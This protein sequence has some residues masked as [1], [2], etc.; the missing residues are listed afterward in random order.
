MFVI[1]FKPYGDSTFFARTE[2]QAGKP[3]CPHP[4]E[5]FSHDALLGTHE[6]MLSTS[7]AA[8]TFAIADEWLAAQSVRRCEMNPASGRKPPHWYYVVAAIAIVRNVMGVAA[9]TNQ[10]AV[11]LS[12]L[13][14]AQRFF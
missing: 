5:D 11:D 3:G 9:Y 7:S 6:R 14:E 4:A 8:D 10:H 12:Q 2:G 13:P 1:Q